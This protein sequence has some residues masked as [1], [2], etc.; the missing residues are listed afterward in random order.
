[1]DRSLLDNSA[2]PM[3]VSCDGLTVA[4]IAASRGNCV[5]QDIVKSFSGERVRKEG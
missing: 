5:V 1:M 2:N 4:D 3:I